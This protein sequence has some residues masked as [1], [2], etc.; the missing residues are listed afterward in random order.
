MMVGRAVKFEIDKPEQAAGSV[1]LSLGI[2]RYAMAAA[3]EGQGLEHGCPRREIVGI[4]GVATARASS[5]ESPASC[6]WRRA[7]SSGWHTHRKLTIRER[8]E[9]GWVHPRG[10][11]EV[12]LVA[13]FTIAENSSLKNYYHERCKALQPPRLC[14]DGEGCRQ[15][16]RAVRHQGAEGAATKAEASRGQPA[17][18]HR[19]AEISLSPKVLVVAQPPVAGR[20][21][22]RHIRKRIID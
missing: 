13:D 5:C 9:A 6:R 10:P 16:D 2:W 15:P 8:I 14:R 22:H 11:A 1:V 18:G 7:P 12:R 17:E 3:G 4:A 20:R 21:G 19:R